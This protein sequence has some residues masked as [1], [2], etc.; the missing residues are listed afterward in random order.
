MSMTT[1]Q[2]IK[3]ARKQKQCDWCNEHIEV[4]SSYVRYR[5]FDGAD[6]VTTSMHPECMKASR[7]FA[8]RE[9]RGCEWTPGEFARGCCCERSLSMRE[10]ETK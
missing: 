3:A 8:H 10:G 7:D 4:G 9:P 6:A 2:T 5:W 1:P